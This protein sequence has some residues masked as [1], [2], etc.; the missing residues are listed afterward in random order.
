MNQDLYSGA[1]IVSANTCIESVAADIEY[2]R[3]FRKGTSV[4]FLH[5]AWKNNKFKCKFWNI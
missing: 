4:A 2:A 3:V 1:K 5:N